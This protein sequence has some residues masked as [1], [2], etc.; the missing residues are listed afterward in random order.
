MSAVVTYLLMLFI[1]LY[2]LLVLAVLLAGRPARG[3]LGQL[4]LLAAVVLLLR[5]TT[6]FPTIREAFGGVS[7][8]AAIGAMMVCTVLGIA[9]E[10]FFRLK[11]PFSWRS[12]LKPLCVSPIVLLPLIGS[13]QSSGTMTSVQFISICFLSFQNGF[14]WRIVL[15]HAKTKI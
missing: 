6:G 7:P 13:V 11:G 5:A 8:V 12:F 9:A 10:Y 14:F 2:A 1:A 3:V 15:D 4:V